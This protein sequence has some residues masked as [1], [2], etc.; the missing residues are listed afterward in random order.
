[1]NAAYG[2]S[3]QQN[4]KSFYNETY[5]SYLCS[6]WD[7]A[8]WYETIF[9]GFVKWNNNKWLWFFFRISWNSQNIF[10]TLEAFKEEELIVSG[11]PLHP[12]IVLLTYFMDV[13]FNQ[14]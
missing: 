5:A 11:D 6:K 8:K 14:R 12:I 13:L 1:M 2:W 9:T 3:Q 4:I 10:S 7:P